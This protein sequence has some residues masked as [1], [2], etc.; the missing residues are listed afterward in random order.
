VSTVPLDRKRITELGQ[1]IGPDLGRVLDSLCQS[2]SSAID[3][4]ADA[5]AAGDP[6]AAAYA[7]HRCRND[8]LMV[9]ARQLQDALGELETASRRRELEP[10][11]EA[12]ERVREIWPTTRDELTQAARSAR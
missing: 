8:A 10:A 4:A 6:A 5:L 1:V 9:G 12:I 11:R 2:I 3:D 7:A